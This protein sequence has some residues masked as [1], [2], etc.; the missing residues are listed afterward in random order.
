RDA[1]A[2]ESIPILRALWG[3]KEPPTTSRFF[4]I[5]PISLAPAPIQPGGPPVWIGGRSPAAIRRAAWL[6]DGYLGYFLDAAGV[7]K[8]MA[9]IRE[10]R[11]EAPSAARRRAPL[12]CALMAFARVDADADRGLRRAQQRLGALYG[13]ETQSTAARFGVVGTLEDCR[14]RVAELAAAGVEHLVLSPIASGEEI[15]DQLEQL[16][17]IGDREAK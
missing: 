15:D 7:R 3:G 14:A 12:A 4:Q 5:P 13:P 6:G 2:D 10:L 11:Q 16:A 17:A 8:R 9:R 1:R